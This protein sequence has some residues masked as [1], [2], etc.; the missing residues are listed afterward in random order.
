MP[1]SIGSVGKYMP[2]PPILSCSRF[3]DRGV[4]KTTNRKSLSNA[5]RA[6][7]TTNKAIG[8]KFKK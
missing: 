5:K 3:S 1:N 4:H 2:I 6:A 8:N 7:N